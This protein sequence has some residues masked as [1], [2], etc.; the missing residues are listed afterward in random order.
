[1]QKLPDLKGTSIGVIWDA[2]KKE[3]LGKVNYT[4]KQFEVSPSSLDENENNN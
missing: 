2:E 3:K 1:M 4:V